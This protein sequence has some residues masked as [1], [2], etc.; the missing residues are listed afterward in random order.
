M[1]GGGIYL[2]LLIGPTVP[3]PAPALVAESLL[4]VEAHF[5]DEGASGF[6]LTFAAGRSGP[7]GAVEHP[8]LALG[9]LRPFNRVICVVNAGPI[10]EVLLDGFITEVRLSPSEQPGASTVTVTGEDVTVMM[11][12]EERSAEHPAQDETLI[13]NVTLASYVQYLLLPPMVIPPT[14]IDPPNPS[15]RIPSQQDTDLTYLRGMAERHAYVFHVTPGPAPGQNLAYWGPKQRIRFPQRALSTNM[16]HATN[17][18][19]ISFSSDGLAPRRVSGTVQDRLTN[20]QLP[21][22]TVAPL[23]PPMSALP[24]AVVQQPTVRTRAFRGS[25]ANVAQAYA[26]AQA[27]TD[28]GGDAVTAT[29]TLD[30]V[31]YGGVLKA[32]GVVGVRGAGWL[33]DGLWYVQDV[34]HIIERGS[35][36]QSF[37]LRRDG[38]GST[39]PAVVP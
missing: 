10:P 2:A 15:E 19:Q 12:L 5:S 37:R 1:S 29:G 31:R 39:V 17:V 7:L 36:R 22:E 24:T 20:A 11:D 14:V 9:L 33:H 13:A 23:R 27:E 28:A 21:V 18:D 8:I 34:S 26:Q 6:E 35:F 25:G 32:R 16:G 30:A 3:L 4:R 38:H